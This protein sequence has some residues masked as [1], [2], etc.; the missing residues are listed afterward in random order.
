M[1]RPAKNTTQQNYNPPGT[2]RRPSHKRGPSGDVTIQNNAET[3]KIP[4]KK[5]TK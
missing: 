5:K 2:T 4:F 1:P 3:C